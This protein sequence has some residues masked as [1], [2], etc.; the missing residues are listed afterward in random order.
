MDV[1]EY[2]AIVIYVLMILTFITLV[3]AFLHELYG[4]EEKKS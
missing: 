1:G 2:F 3:L 4:E